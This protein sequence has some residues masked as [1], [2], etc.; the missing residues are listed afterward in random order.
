[1]LATVTVGEDGAA[2]AV[3]ATAATSGDSTSGDSHRYRWRDQIRDTVRAR[4][5]P[6]S[7][8][9]WI[10][11]AACGALVPIRIVQARTSFSPA[12]RNDIRPS[13]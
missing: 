9:V 3:A 10:S 5:K 6:H 2:D 7:M 12:V 1:M 13:M 8:L 11:P 4:M